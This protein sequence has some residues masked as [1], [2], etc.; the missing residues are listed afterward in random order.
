MKCTLL[1][2]ETVIF[3]RKEVGC[4]FGMKDS[5]EEG[6]EMNEKDAEVFEG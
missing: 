6:G 4:F 5:I 1:Y 2:R 3:G